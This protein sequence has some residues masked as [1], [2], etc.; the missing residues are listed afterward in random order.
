M[1]SDLNFDISFTALIIQMTF[2]IIYVVLSM[3]IY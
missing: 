2:L 3:F 1:N